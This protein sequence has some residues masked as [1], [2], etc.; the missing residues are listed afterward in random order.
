[1][2]AQ[3]IV[4]LIGPPRCGSCLTFYS[5]QGEGFGYN[6]GKKVKGKKTKEKNKNV[7]SGMAVFLIIRREQF[8]L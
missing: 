4:F 8:T 2:L 5:S 6:C 3:P 1:V 7:V